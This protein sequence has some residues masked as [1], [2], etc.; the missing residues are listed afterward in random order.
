MPGKESESAPQLR[1]QKSKYMYNQTFWKFTGLL[2]MKG[3]Y[4]IL[5]NLA[6]HH[7]SQFQAYRM[8]SCH[9]VQKCWK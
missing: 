7:N 1:G 3:S 5:I 4:N 8:I 2:I 6:L 9:M